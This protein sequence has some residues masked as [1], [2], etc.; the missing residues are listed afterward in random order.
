METHIARTLQRSPQNLAILHPLVQMITLTVKIKITK[1][2]Y[3]NYLAVWDAST[4]TM[5]KSI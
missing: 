2:T 1:S 5:V 3:H 4:G